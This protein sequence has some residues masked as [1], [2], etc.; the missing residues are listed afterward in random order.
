MILS[1]FRKLLNLIWKT[2]KLLSPASQTAC[3]HSNNFVQIPILINQHTGSSN[4]VMQGLRN[5]SS[6]IIQ[7]I[8]YFGIMNR[9]IGRSAEQLIFPSWITSPGHAKLDLGTESGFKQR[10]PSTNPTTSEF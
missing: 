5:C 7:I 9:V 8:P 3:Y 1:L 4:D 6:A 10:E 2:G